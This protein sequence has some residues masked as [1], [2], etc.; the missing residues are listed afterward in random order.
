MA[1]ELRRRGSRVPAITPGR[2]ERGGRGVRDAG[3]RQ[4]VGAVFNRVVE[5]RGGSTCVLVFSVRRSKSISATHLHTLVRGVIVPGFRRL[6]SAAFVP[7]PARA[8]GRREH[9]APPAG[10]E[11]ADQD[12][13]V[14]PSH[15]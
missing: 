8:E 1:A 13:D 7:F 5:G 3:V 12:D 15:G 2:A 4:A 14:K 6:R 10:E 9:G 11:Q